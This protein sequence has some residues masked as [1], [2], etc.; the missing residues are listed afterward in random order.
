MS[1]IIAAFQFSRYFQNQKMPSAYLFVDQLRHGENSEYIS[2][3]VRRSLPEES[4]QESTLFLSTL[5]RT[6]PV[7]SPMTVTS[8]KLSTRRNLI[9]G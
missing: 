1:I 3:L 8:I 6:V 7:K 4:V 5:V 9:H 2:D